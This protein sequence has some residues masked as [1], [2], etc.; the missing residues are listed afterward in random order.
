M[1]LGD[2]KPRKVSAVVRANLVEI[3]RSL[4]RGLTRE[5]VWDELKKEHNLDHTFH[6]FYT[7]LQRERTKAAQA[8]PTPPQPDSPRSQAPAPPQPE[9][10]DCAIQNPGDPAKEK[11]DCAIQK[12]EA[13][14][15]PAKPSSPKNAIRTTKQLRESTN[16]NF[17]DLTPNKY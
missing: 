17:D 8:A 3:E 7:A 5:Q 10:V 9:K 2:L 11:V 15:T 16:V 6:A 1:A 4:E 13:D 14:Q 12:A